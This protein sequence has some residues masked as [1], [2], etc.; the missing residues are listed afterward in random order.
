MK[1]FLRYGP[2]VLAG[3]KL[4]HG[5][6]RE[7]SKDACVSLIDDYVLRGHD[8]G[9][10]AK[11]LR[12]ACGLEPTQ[13]GKSTGRAAARPVVP[14]GIALGCNGDSQETR[15]PTP[16]D[17][18]KSIVKAMLAQSYHGLTEHY[19]RTISLPAK[20]ERRNKSE[21]WR[22][23]KQS[24]LWRRCFSAKSTHM[25][26]PVIQTRRTYAEVVLTPDV[27]DVCQLQ[28]TYDLPALRKYADE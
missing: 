7:H 2:G 13:A 11:Y 28:E 12:E 19:L 1:P 21:L 16:D 6:E 10:T 14:Q 20:S 17:T 27:A 25:L 15:G 8:H 24:C 23:M 5:F 3:L 9:I 4:Q 26:L 22:D 18:W